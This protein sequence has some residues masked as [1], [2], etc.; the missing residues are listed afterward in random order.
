MIL[1]LIMHIVWVRVVVHVCALGVLRGQLWSLPDMGT[2][3][4]SSEMCF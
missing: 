3:V 1:L 2:K 4:G